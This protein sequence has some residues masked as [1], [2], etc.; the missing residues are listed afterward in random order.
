MT[1]KLFIWVLLLSLCLLH[2]AMATDFPEGTTNILALAQ[3]QP[4]Y[5]EAI[6][7]NPGLSPTSDGRSFYLVWKP[8]GETPQDWIVSLH[9]HGSFATDDLVAWTRHLAG[10][11]I[12]LISLQWWLGGDDA[13]YYMPNELYR[14]IDIAMRH[15]NIKPRR[16]MLEGFSRGSANIY[17]V[18]AMDVQTGNNY[19]NL[20]VANAGGAAADYPPTKAIT[21]GR[22]G[23]RPFTGTTWVTVCGMKDEHPEQDGCPAMRRT[24]EWIT[25]M[26]G[27]VADRIEDQNLGHGALHMSPQNVQ[28]LLDIFQNPNP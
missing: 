5:Q 10:K 3:K 4:R 22:F 26:G 1:L 19:F 11:H 13:D 20:T 6:K 12:G 18:K 24:A 17:A 2:P 16:I 14:E 15:L 9:G 25:S 27:I 28:H 21:S 23:A 8:E 7:L